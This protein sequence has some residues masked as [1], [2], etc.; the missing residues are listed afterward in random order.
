MARQMLYMKRPSDALEM[1]RMAQDGTRHTAGPR[2]RSMLQVREAWAYAA[3]GRG[4]AF[5]RAT[6]QAH[7]SLSA[8]G[9]EDDEPHWIAYFDEAELRGTIGGRYLDL[10]HH[11]PRAHAETALTEIGA[12]LAR[13]GPEAGRSHALDRIG[14][15]ECHFLLGDL[16]TAVDETHRSVDITLT[17]RSSRVREKLSELYDHTTSAKQNSAVRDARERIRTA[18]T[19]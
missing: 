6:D 15:A 18:L 7:D 19:R 1:I 11:D 2:L 3:M 16:S 10:A 9:S 4:A 17:S 8:A 14:L 13:R 12:A 5:R